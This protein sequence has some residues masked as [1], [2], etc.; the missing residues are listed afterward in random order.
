MKTRSHLTVLALV[1][2]FTC[3]PVVSAADHEIAAATPATPSTEKSAKNPHGWPVLKKGMPADEV[4]RSIG[5][6]ESIKPMQTPEGKAEVWI[7]RRVANS[8]SRQAAVTTES[9]PAFNGIGV[10]NDSS[11]SVT[12]PSYRMEHITVYQVSSL[13]MFDGKLVTATQKVEQ[14][15]HFE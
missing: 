3:G 4:I 2:G 6:P 9:V 15:S 11:G 7:Y 5:K 1:A 10:G 14:E 12:I 8:V 13:L